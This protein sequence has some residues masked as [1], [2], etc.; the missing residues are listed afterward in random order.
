MSAREA[1]R[2][3]PVAPEGWDDEVRAAIDAGFGPGAAERLCSDDADTPRMP[4]VLATLMHHPALTGPW[5]AYNN[6]LLN[7]PTIDPRHRELLVLRVAWRTR[8]R[9]EWVQHVRI[10]LRVG[11]TAEQIDAIA[12]LA[13]TAEWSPLETD[14]L[15][16]TDQLIDH[17]CIDEATWARLAEH[18]VERQLV[19]VVFVVGTY[20]CLAMAFNSFGLQLDPD[21]DG[22]PAP[23]MPEPRS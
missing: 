8:A 21:L 15:L 20:T 2:L 7:A 6:V 3:A 10:A 16:A 13:P 19:E 4:N 9:Y 18:L 17:H 12:G 14:L 11:I 5:L 22:V 1:P 23:A